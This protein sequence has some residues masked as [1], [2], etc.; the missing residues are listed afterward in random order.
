[1]NNPPKKLHSITILRLLA[2]VPWLAPLSLQAQFECTTNQGAVTITKYTGSGGD[3]AIPSTITGLPVTAIADWAFALC[4]TVTSVSIPNTVSNIGMS[5]FSYCNGLTK[6]NIPAGVT[7]IGAGAFNSC[8][9]LSAIDVDPSNPVYRSIDGVLF[10]LSL[11]ALLQY[12]GGKVGNYTIPGTVKSLQAM[13]FAGSLRLT[14]IT[15]PNSVMTIPDWAFDSCISLTAVK[16]PTDL[17]SIGYLAFYYSGLTNVVVPKGVTQVVDY[18]FAHC[19]SLSAVYFTGNAPTIGDNSF[20]NDTAATLYYLPG[21]SG[22]SQISPGLPVVPWNPQMHTAAATLGPPESP[23]AF[24]ITGSSD[25]PIVV[26][27][28]DGLPGTAW[29][30]LQSCT[31]TNGSLYFRDLNWMAYPARFYRIRSP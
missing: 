28:G 20:E 10:D 6:V 27:A 16:L 29:V 13:A 3:L 21:N 17:T 24:T 1:M 31:L 30:P 22:W 18:A 11:T 26:E 7:Y 19:Y 4:E 12:P 15:I 8:M 23:F 9:S 5:V 14:G 2:A 25:I